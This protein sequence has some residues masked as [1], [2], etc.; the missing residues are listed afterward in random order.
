MVQRGMVSELDRWREEEDKSQHDLNGA[1]FIMKGEKGGGCLSVC[2]AGRRV[3]SQSSLPTLRDR[4]K[5]GR[6]AHMV[7]AMF[8]PLASKDACFSAS[9]CWRCWLQ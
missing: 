6:R 8:L 3:R 9:L 5:Q 2:K 7:G 1:V 4:T